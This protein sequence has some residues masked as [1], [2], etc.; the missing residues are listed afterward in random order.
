MRILTV[1][2]GTGTQDIWLFDSSQEPE[3][4]VKLI[5]PSPTA[6]VATCIRAATTRGEPVVL[7]GTTMGGGP[8]H[9]AA[10]DHARAGHRLWAT[11][12]AARTFDDELDKV[13][14]M[15]IEIISDDEAATLT[16][17][18]TREIEMRDFDLPRIE[19][20]LRLFG[21]E[22]A[23][24]AI[25]VAVF[26]HG[27][28]PPGVS[29]RKFR[30]AYIAEMLRRNSLASFAYL[31]D[32]VPP[33]LTRMRA[34]VASTQT[35]MPL[36]LMD[37]GPA[38]ILGALDD[39]TARQMPNK[40]VCNVGNF[41][42]LAFHLLDERIAGVFEHHTGELSPEELREYLRKLANGT[43]TDQE[44]FEDMGHGAI[45]QDVERVDEPHLVVTGPRRATIRA[46]GVPAHFAVPHG[47]MMITGCIGLLRAF[48]DQVPA[49]R[50]EIERALG[51]SHVEHG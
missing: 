3:N 35:D 8:S 27:N 9:W 1:D 33:H 46:A 7:T 49:C 28:A 47:D 39:P 16:R 40:I 23:L 12:T 30:F 51:P 2:I 15:G 45:V 11:E 50:E 22:P 18:G 19:K 24:D 14:A 21:V 6:V 13:A 44:V 43:L 10:V 26:D 37:T 38:A 34:V 36:L 25:A 42:C 17:R 41:H 32:R 5:M 48:A 4:F 20:A 29:D 31:S